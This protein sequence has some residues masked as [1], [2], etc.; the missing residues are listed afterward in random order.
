MHTLAPESRRIVELCLKRDVDTLGRILEAS[1]QSH[2]SS[3]LLSPIRGQVPFADLYLLHGSVDNVIP[4][5]ETEALA[6][7]ASGATNT[8]VLVTDLITHVELEETKER[9][10][11][12]YYDIIRFF[13]ELLR[14]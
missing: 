9:S 7:W 6:R 5:S 4:R 2:K 8:R 1:V 3:D 13:T 14:S 10:F 12:E 11:S